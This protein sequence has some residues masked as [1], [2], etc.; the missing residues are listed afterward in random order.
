MGKGGKTNIH[1]L[2]III[3][4]STPILETGDYKE[5]ERRLPI[6]ARITLEN[7]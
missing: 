5:H 6:Q 1:A 3:Q 7:R 2:H 4:G